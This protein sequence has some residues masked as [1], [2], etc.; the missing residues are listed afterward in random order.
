MA[1]TANPR[2]PRPPAVPVRAPETPLAGEVS[3]SVQFFADEDDVPL[4]LNRLNDDPELAFIVCEGRLPSPATRPSESG[5]TGREDVG[6]TPALS[7]HWKATKQVQSLADGDHRLWHFA[8]YPL[9]PARDG[10]G[11][12]D[13]PW[14][15]WTE[16]VEEG[17]RAGR[18]GCAPS[19][20]IHLQL[21]SR[22]RPYTARELSSGAIKASW[23]MEG[24]EFLASSHISWIGNRY[25]SIGAPAHPSTVRWW[26]RL[27]RWMGT[28]T[29][30]LKVRRQ[31]FF[32]F[33]S[34]LVR[35]RSG[36][37]YYSHGWDLGPVLNSL[38]P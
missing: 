31:V 33:P 15:G 11:P 35:L 3:S 13:D 1:Q 32:A 14:A 4:L 25:A 23:W 27:R 34:A 21:W 37:A 8:G 7:I 38:S 6:C 17:P 5:V 30:P 36:I 10:I 16:V 9:S 29:T 12:T 24:R 2:S 18:L 20:L 26:A 28:N 19:S 22:H